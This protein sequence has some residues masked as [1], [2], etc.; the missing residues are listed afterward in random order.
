M[1]CPFFEPLERLRDATVRVPLGDFWSGACHANAESLFVPDDHT[2]SEYCNMGYARGRCPRFP[3]AQSP[4]A[5]RFLV[6]RDSAQVIEIQFAME[7]NHHPHSHG[8]LEFSSASG[9]FTQPVEGHLLEQQARAYAASYLRRRR[10]A[11]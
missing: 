9:T 5:V 10:A 4:D 8:K 6:V 1:A 7:Q 3:A 11:A 2:I